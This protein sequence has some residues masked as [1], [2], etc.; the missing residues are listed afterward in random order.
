MVDGMATLIG[1]VPVNVDVSIART[2]GGNDEP[3]R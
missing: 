2:W 3:A 1:P